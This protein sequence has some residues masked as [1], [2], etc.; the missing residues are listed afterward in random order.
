M[1]VILLLAATMKPFWSWSF[2]IL[3]KILYSDLHSC[4]P[5]IVHLD[6]PLPCSWPAPASSLWNSWHIWVSAWHILHFHLHLHLLQVFLLEFYLPSKV[7]RFKNFNPF[8]TSQY[9]I[10]PFSA[11]M[12]SHWHL[13]S[14]SLLCILLV[15]LVYGLS[16]PSNLSSTGQG[17]LS[18]VCSCVTNV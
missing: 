1:S 17:F 15:Y 4:P 13:A 12:G 5:Q 16:S 3:I 9:S 6:W 14:T 11:C 18:V 8:P 10:S 7:F 2:K